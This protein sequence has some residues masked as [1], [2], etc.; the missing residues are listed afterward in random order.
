[1]NLRQEQLLEHLKKWSE[2]PISR[3]TI[4]KNLEH[5]YPSDGSLS[6]YNDVAY[7][8]ITKDIQ[9][10]NDDLGCDY[11]IISK[12]SG[13][14][15]ASSTDYQDELLQERR[16]ILRRLIRVHTKMRKANK[17]DTLRFNFLDNEVEVIKSLIGE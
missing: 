12:P 11:F 10:I 9:A 16:A 15:I 2:T 17:H 8:Q 6:H 5:L 7:A 3:E 13:I 1:M 4:Q 14:K